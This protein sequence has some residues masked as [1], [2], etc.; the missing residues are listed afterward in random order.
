[1]SILRVYFS[2]QWRDSTS[3]CPWA[4]CDDNGMPVQSGIATVA[5]LPKGHD[6][7]AIVAAD[8]VL[9]IPVS[10]PT[11]GRRR[12]QSVLPYVAEE[13]TVADPEDSHVVP[14]PV[15]DDGRRMVLVV[16]KSF[17][18]RIVDAAHAAKLSLRRM[19]AETLLPELTHDSWTM[20]WNGSSGFVKTGTASGAALDIGDEHT[21]PLAL[22]LTLQTASELP[23]KIILRYLK[24][25]PLEQRS[26]PNWSD[27]HLPLIP[28]EDWDWSSADIAEDSVN[29]LWGSFAPRAKIQEWLP[30]LRPAAF[31]LL[32]VLALET[33]GSNIEWAM[34]AYQKNT[35]S[36]A[37]Q[38][39]FRTTFGD[40][41]MLVNAALQMQRKLADLKH[42]AGLADTGD[43]LPLLNQVGRPLAAFPAGSVTSIHYEAGRLDLNIKLAQKTD[44][45]T[46]KK[47][48]QNNGVNVR[49]G[50]I[51][52]TG[53]GVEAKL[54][55][56]PEGVQ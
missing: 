50:E 49:V 11:G 33:I 23:K 55:V 19:I 54:T 46:L 43:F 17:L 28:G 29:L 16:D 48:I 21:P 6:C 51:R 45:E 27:V 8:C 40:T 30:K 42:G 15:L 52:D 12:W 41:V 18:K 25:V 44:F 7:V 22:G 39:T 9:S 3:T 38:K 2:A 36:K 20:V 26:M 34:L 32:A 10:L 14:G 37:M 13:F 31:L 53:N 47:N 56:L 1:M 24:D 5:T 35:L 4:L